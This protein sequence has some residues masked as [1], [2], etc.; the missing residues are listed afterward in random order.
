ME[1]CSLKNKRSIDDFYIGQE[2]I[3]ISIVFGNYYC[4]KII[5]ID[6]SDLQYPIAIPYPGRSN[7]IWL[8]ID[9]TMPATTLLK[10]IFNKGT[11]DDL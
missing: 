2:V 7:R 3:G 11:G 5:D 6:L 9:H 10:I 4:G 1:T 8:D